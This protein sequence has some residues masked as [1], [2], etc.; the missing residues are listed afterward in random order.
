M[1][2]CDLLLRSATNP[3]GRVHAFIY[4]A[5]R[6]YSP[7]NGRQLTFL[8]DLKVSLHVGITDH[9]VAKSTAQMQNPLDALFVNVG[10][11]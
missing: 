5:D 9:T 4:H 2:C 8:G 11:G 7:K 6:K 3:Q 1:L 10:R